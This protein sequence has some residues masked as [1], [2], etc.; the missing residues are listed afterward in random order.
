M[1]R[2]YIGLMSGTS[3]D[4]IDVALVDFSHGKPVLVASHYQAYDNITQS[5]ITSLYLSSDNEIERMGRLD[6]ALAKQFSSAVKTLLANASL[7]AEQIIAIGNHG[8]TIRH[9]PS[10]ASQAETHPFTLQIGC[11]QTLACLTGIP[12]VGQFRLKD[13]ALGGQGAP[14]VPP[15]H[16][17]LLAGTPAANNH[18]VIVNIGGIA[19]LTYLPS[20]NQDVQGYDTGPGNCL[21]DDWYQQHH[22]DSYFDKNGEWA[23]SGAYN[24]KLLNTL[25][26]DDFFKQPAPKSTGREVYNLAWLN[27]HLDNQAH[28]PEDVQATLLKLTARTIADQIKKLIA[29]STQTCAVWLCGGGRLNPTLQQAL[30]KELDSVSVA[31]IELLEIDGDQLE[32]MAFAWLAFAYINQLPSNMPAVT[33]A[34]KATTLG[35]LFLP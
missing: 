17:F 12:V 16:Q 21:L 13:I 34:E 2:Y 22:Q 32:A 6:K 4:G 8:Q 29:G 25:L 31:A 24:Q 11:S 20:N 5:Q 14:L 23:A 7:D 10:L 35:A 28:K 33:G 1:T 26:S 18:N 9:R 30:A 27:K 15:F 3:A 19:N